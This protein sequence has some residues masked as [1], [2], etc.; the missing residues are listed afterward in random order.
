MIPEDFRALPD[1]QQQEM[2]DYLTE[3]CPSCGNLKSVCSDPAYRG[4]PQRTHCYASAGREQ[5]WR[6]TRK[7]FGHPAPDDPGPHITDGLTW[8]MSQH[9]LTP[10]DDFF[11]DNQPTLGAALSADREADD[12]QND[13]DADQQGR[14]VGSA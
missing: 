9:D 1:E 7:V 3:L 8:W 4:F 6:R 5:M 11:G 13:P 14:H 2:T 12:R 10:D